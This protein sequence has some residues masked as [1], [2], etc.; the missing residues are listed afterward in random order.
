MYLFLWFLGNDASPQKVIPMECGMMPLY[1][2]VLSL[3]RLV[4]SPDFPY[5]QVTKVA[6]L[7]AGQAE[8]PTL[9]LA[10]LS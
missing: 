6:P 9:C 8:G 1:S 10:H 3:E 4:P 2:Q 7:L 5:H